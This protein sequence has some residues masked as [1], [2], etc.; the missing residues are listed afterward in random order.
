MPATPHEERRGWATSHRPPRPS[1]TSTWPTTR[2]RRRRQSQRRGA[3]STLVAC[4][5]LA[6]G[7][8]VGLHR[9]YLN[10]PFFGWLLAWG[11]GLG[12][13]PAALRW[14]RTLGAPHWPPLARPLPHP[15]VGPSETMRVW[16]RPPPHR[17][18]LQVRSLASVALPR[19]HSRKSPPRRHRSRNPRTSG[20]FCSTPRTAA[21]AS[22][23][24][25]RPS[26]KPGWTGSPWR[27]ACGRWSARDTSTWTTSPTV[28][29]SSTSF[30]SWWDARDCA[31]TSSTRTPLGIPSM[32]R[33][34]SGELS[35]QTAAAVCIDTPR[36]VLPIARVDPQKGRETA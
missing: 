17:C 8:G 36:L 1:S 6:L 33:Q 12:R 26:W 13:H 11:D 18:L 7:G 4:V 24:S 10:R 28:A 20:P 32:Y 5:L 30:R 21:T 23:R 19:P 31:S 16:L 9:M 3:K 22:S 14:R 2:P 35:I 25:P 29:S 34:F 27:S 15:A